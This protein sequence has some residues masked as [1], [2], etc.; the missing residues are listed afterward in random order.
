MVN[1]TDWT[2]NNMS[3]RYHSLAIFLACIV[4]MKVAHYLAESPAYENINGLICSSSSRNDNLKSR[5]CWNE[6]RV[7][8][9]VILPTNIILLHLYFS[10]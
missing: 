7:I 1:L 6:G 8:A 9:S 2:I 5:T 4:V 10:G 3:S